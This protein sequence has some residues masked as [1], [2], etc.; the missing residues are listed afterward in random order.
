MYIESVML[1]VASGPEAGGLFQLAVF[2]Y[3]QG[4]DRHFSAVP[5]DSPLRQPSGKQERSARCF[6][7]SARWKC[8]ARQHT[9]SSLNLSGPLYV[10]RSGPNG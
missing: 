7:A 9:S 4:S 8:R 3:I 1:F 2:R 10:D 6:E 5:A